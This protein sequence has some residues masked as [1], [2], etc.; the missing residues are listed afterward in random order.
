MNNKELKSDKKFSHSQI[1]MI[2]RTFLGLRMQ[3]YLLASP[4]VSGSGNTVQ[5]KS[6]R[7]DRFYSSILY[8]S[9]EKTLLKSSLFSNFLRTPLD[10]NTS[11]YNGLR[12]PTF[13]NANNES[14]E[15]TDCLFTK[16][17]SSKTEP[18]AIRYQPIYDNS[19]FTIS[20]STFLLCNSESTFGTIYTNST[21]VS[22]S[23]CCFREC[24]AV[25]CKGVL[26]FA[27]S[28]SFN[29]NCSM[30]SADQNQGSN[31]SAMFYL[32]SEQSQFEQ[33]NISGIICSGAAFLEN[34]QSST[35]KFSSFSNIISSQL[36]ECN[37]VEILDSK[38]TK[39]NSS[40][41]LV[42]QSGSIANSYFIDVV[43]DTIINGS[44]EI[45]NCYYDKEQKLGTL[46]FENASVESIP[47]FGFGA[48]YCL[49]FEIRSDGYN[50]TWGELSYSIAYS[51]YIYIGFIAIL[52]V[53]YVLYRKKLKE[54][55]DATVQTEYNSGSEWD[56]NDG[57]REI[58]A[59]VDNAEPTKESPL[60]KDQQQK[61]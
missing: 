50:T 52:L 26:V 28:T 5:F 41:Y 7:F 11:T 44:F 61:I 39:I 12:G 2:N 9:F 48:N 42:G 4:L 47:E 27:N 54:P 36:I 22:A 25:N 53:V 13:I 57:I 45:S 38:F 43:A 37:K 59:E 8:G 10:V 58:I 60:L 6:S 20:D 24:Y 49:G 1:I 16:L 18:S 23:R 15:I 35:I 3:N 56:E 14:L 21:T 19:V 51:T 30:I 40:L 31:S 55:V 34:T 46:P 33:I 32:M 29:F 17:Q